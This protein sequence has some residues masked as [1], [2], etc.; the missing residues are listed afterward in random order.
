VSEKYEVY[1]YIFQN[2]RKYLGGLP[3]RY[4]LVRNMKLASIFFKMSGVSWRFTSKIA[5]NGRKFCRFVILA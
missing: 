5:T 2:E 1:F 4:K 3:Q